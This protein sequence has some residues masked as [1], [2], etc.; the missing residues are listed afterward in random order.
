MGFHV[1]LVTIYTYEALN[2]SQDLQWFTATCPK[3]CPSVPDW[4]E[5]S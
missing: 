2:I 3:F 5:I 1:P 4:I